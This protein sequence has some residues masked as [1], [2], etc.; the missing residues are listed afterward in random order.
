MWKRALVLSVLL[1]AGCAKAPAPL[2]VPRSDSA[3]DDARRTDHGPAKSPTSSR[4]PAEPVREQVARAIETLHAQRFS[5]LLHFESASERVFVSANPAPRGVDAG[6]AHTGKSS[7]LLA[8][9]TQRLTVKLSSVLAGRA[10][11]GDWTLVG[12]YVRS[13]EANGVS[14]SCQ[15]NGRAIASRKV[16]LPAGEWTAAML[17]VS[18][19][20]AAPGDDVTL[21]LRFDESARGARCDDVLLIDNRETLVDASPNGWTVK[22][23]GFRITCERKLRFSFGV[24]TAGGSPAGWAVEEANELRARFTSSGETKALTVYAD[25]RSLW[26]GA[27]KPLAVEVRDDKS[28]AAAHAA[29]AELAVPETMGRVGRSTPG[30][31]NNDG[32]NEQLGA[33]Q[34]EATGGRLELTMTPRGTPVPR[35]VLQIAGM[36]Q[37]RALVTIE[38]RLVEKSIR[39]KDGQ[40]LVELPARITRATLVTVRIQ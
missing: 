21:E 32:Y 38:G 34:I 26:D 4:S 10:F 33:Y 16:A 27:Y 2:P 39:L 40:L 11:P 20:P 6:D 5:G 3:S 23:A 15:D 28:F 9:G 1:A 29:P 31:A 14:I 12:L 36:P 37:G 25:G 19:L 17:D 8:P 24:V 18:A 7:L 30:D 22:R 13:D 35:P